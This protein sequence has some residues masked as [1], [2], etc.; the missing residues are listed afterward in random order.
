MTESPSFKVIRYIN[1]VKVKEIPH[2]YLENDDCLQVIKE[3]H[4]KIRRSSS[5]Y[6][7]LDFY[8]QIILVFSKIYNKTR[9]LLHKFSAL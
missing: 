5:F 6:T 7:F 8:R 3:L 1:G 4:R 9:C 2:M